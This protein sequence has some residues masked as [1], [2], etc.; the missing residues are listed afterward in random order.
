MTFR[1]ATPDDLDVGSVVHCEG[2]SAI[3]GDVTDLELDDDGDLISVTV[4]WRQTETTE[5]PDDLI[6]EA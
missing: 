5:D 6:V 3:L 2:S 4:V 1:K